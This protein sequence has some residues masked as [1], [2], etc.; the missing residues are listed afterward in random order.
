MM[1]I[2]LSFTLQANVSPWIKIAEERGAIVRW[3]EVNIMPRVKF[4]ARRHLAIDCVGSHRCL[5]IILPD[6]GDT[7]TYP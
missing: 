4:K 1:L 2:Y 7:E 6:S 5:S 3:I